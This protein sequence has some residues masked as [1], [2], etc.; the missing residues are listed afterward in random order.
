MH[1]VGTD[2]HSMLTMDGRLYPNSVNWIVSRVSPF[3]GPLLS[4]YV[5]IRLD[6]LSVASQAL[7]GVLR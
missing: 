3:A 5:W 6:S 4:A 7:G 2:G 1:S